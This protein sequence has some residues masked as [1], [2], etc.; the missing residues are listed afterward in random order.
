MTEQLTQASGGFKINTIQNRIIFYI[1]LF[2]V[3][4]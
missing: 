2:I 4:F 3:P 1:F